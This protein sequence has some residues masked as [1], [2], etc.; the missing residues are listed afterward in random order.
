MNKK[1]KIAGMALL[2]CTALQAQSFHFDFTQN[3]KTPDGFTKVTVA[4]TFNKEKGYG[5]DRIPV[6]PKNPKAPF[7]FS[8]QVPDGNYHVTA[9]L[10]NKKYAGMTTVRGESSRLFGE[11]IATKK[12]QTDTLRFVINKRNT[13]INSKQR[14]GIKPRETTKMNWD[15]KL[16][17][18]FNGAAPALSQ[19]IIERVD[20]VPTIFLCGN[21]T[22]V[23]QD[24]EP[25]ASWGQMLPRWLDDKVCVANYAESGESAN[26]FVGARRLAKILTQMKKGDYLFVEFGHNDQKQKGPGKGA[27]YSF[28]TS[29]KVFIDEA[30]ARGAYPV[31][32]TP[33]CRRRFD[34]NKKIINSHGEFP[35]AIRWIAKKENVP[36]IELNQMTKKMYEA[37]GDDTSKKAFVHYPANTFPG[38]SKALADNTH[39]N[40]F[41]AYEISKCI[42]EGIKKLN[43]PI[44]K[45]I[46][47]DYVTFDP[48]HPDQPS[49]FKWDS[50]PSSE[51]EKPDGN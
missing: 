10:G 49:D 25:W 7:F 43:L 42:V 33:T 19:L 29:L 41:G 30:R 46:R 9:I 13:I 26:T 38:Q 36:V 40:P 37:W 48:S 39:F 34:E 20:N 16:T 22:V 28:M 6:D 12:G 11:H 3:K 14:V 45:D 15:D 5:Y 50:R 51:V 24:N 27:Y 32:V 23:D 47:P 8:V 31:L 35:D 2:F 44:A 21:S 17:L 1:I 18:E 4:D